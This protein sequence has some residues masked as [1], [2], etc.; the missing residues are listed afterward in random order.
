VAWLALLMGLQSL[1]GLLLPGQYRDAELIR[2]GWFANDLVTLTV[3]VPVLSWSLRSASQN[4]G[5]ALLLKL[6]VIAYAVYNYAYYLFGAALNAF[7]PLYVALAVLSC[8]SL[9]S[10]LSEVNANEVAA[11]FQPSTRNRPI[12]A[13]FVSVGAALAVIWIV[14]WAAYVFFK[15]PTPVDPEM[16]RLIAALDITLLSTPLVIGG[17][18]LSRGT[19]WGYVIGPLAGI[20]SAL[21]LLVL[22]ASSV[23][24]IRRGLVEAPGEL[25]VWNTLAALTLVAVTILIA[26]VKAGPHAPAALCRA[27]R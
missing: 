24:S 9:I 16:F 12:G 14:M 2:A 25:P 23:V 17:W 13:Y 5:R 26:G 22:S 3:A 19:P 4:S 20:Q 6:G 15:R 8:A 10:A 21:Y 18:L 1:L 27:R 11:R 7:F